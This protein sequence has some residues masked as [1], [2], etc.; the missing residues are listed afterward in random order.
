M[1]TKDKYY[2]LDAPNSGKC[3]HVGKIRMVSKFSR[4]I[5]LRYRH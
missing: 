5:P 3:A 1:K 2:C 4:V